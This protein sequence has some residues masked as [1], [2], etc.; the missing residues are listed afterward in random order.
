LLSSSCQAVPS[1]AGV[2]VGS[3]IVTL[4]RLSRLRVA[5]SSMR[6]DPFRFPIPNNRR[7]GGQEQ[8]KT[9]GAAMQFACRPTRRAFGLAWLGG[10]YQ[11]HRPFPRVIRLGS[12]LANGGS[13]LVEGGTMTPSYLWPSTVRCKRAAWIRSISKQCQC[14]S[15]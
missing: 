14:S 9:T 4:H 7:V 6:G 3:I 2:T 8:N 11:L 12:L 13:P 5:S 10:C 15:S 1:G